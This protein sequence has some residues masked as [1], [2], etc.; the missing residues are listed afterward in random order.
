M[1]DLN[2]SKKIG[3]GLGHVLNDLCASMWFTYLLLFFH[4]VLDFNN[5]YSGVILL[6]GQIADGISTTLVGGLMDKPDYFWLCR[7][8]GQK[9]SWHL[10]GT[11]CV[12]ISFPFIFLPCIG[13][14]GSDEWAQLIYY[15]AF[16]VIFQFG[17]ASV[18][19]SHLALIPSLT[20]CQNERTGLTALRYAMTVI[21]NITVFLIAWAF[22]GMNGQT[23]IDEK[24]VQSFR[25][26]MLVVIGIGALTSLAFHLIV[27][28]PIMDVPTSYGE[29]NETGEQRDFVEP[30]S[31]TDWFKEPQF[32]QVAGVYMCTRLFVNL[33]QAYIPL[34]LQESL[35]LQG[36]FV[37]IV[38]LVMYCSSF[39]TSG[40]VKIL[41]QKAGRKF[42][43][44]L[45]ALVGIASASW[46]YYAG[47]EETGKA[48]IFFKNYGIFFVAAL[49]GIAG[50]A[51]L[52]TSLSI[53]AEL[54]GPNTETS[55]FVYGSM[56]FTDK[57]SNGLAVMVIQH[58]IPCLKCCILCKWY[59][60]DVLFFA[61]G[62]AALCGLIFL[63]SLV[64]Y[65][66]GSRRRDNVSLEVE[67][68]SIFTRF[69][70]WRTGTNETRG[71][72]EPLLGES[73]SVVYT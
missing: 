50:S 73:S 29:I 33:S 24:D 32:Y 16:A 52:I 20:D 71:E 37:A 49:F 63:C 36:K 45:G 31:I 5:N 51:S 62:G 3:Y 30:M 41:N 9:K 14:E 4:Q 69:A 7:R 27:P 66:I 47:E 12:L 2:L 43:F 67:S 61:T 53:T 21:S 57:V 34:Y 39:V 1:G 10:I 64:P 70:K 22:F 44:S 40:L 17:W 25:N 56:S 54:I 55:A 23:L 48:L 46:V 58:F 42:S 65:K 38:P 26:I 13:C 19:I 6:V 28:E 8:Y 72:R 18:Q 15:S 59:F 11:L 60:R 35:Q 68:Q